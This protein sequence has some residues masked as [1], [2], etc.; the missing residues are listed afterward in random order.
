MRLYLPI[1]ILNIKITGWIDLK[2][3][4]E[5]VQEFQAEDRICIFAAVFGMSIKAMVGIV[6]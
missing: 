2:G 1:Y 6:W 5:H 4:N 3:K